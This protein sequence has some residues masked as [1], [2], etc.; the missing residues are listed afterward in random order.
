MRVL[1][2]GGSGNISSM[3]SKAAV[4]A[5]MELI[6]L[7]RGESTRLRNPEAYPAIKAD[8]GNVEQ[9]AKALRGLDFDA[10][11]DWIAYDKPDVE[12][13][14]GLFKGHTKQFIFISTASAYQRPLSHPVITEGTPL[15]NV[16]WE[17]SRKKIACET[18]LME[19]YREE[20]FPVTIVR[21]SHT[22]NTI[23]PIPVGRSNYTV[24]RRML[25][26]KSI[27]VPGD[28]SSLWTVTHAEDFAKGLVGLIGNMRAIGHAFHITSDEILTWNQII[29]TLADALGVK[30]NI[31]HMPSDF[32]SRFDEEIRG[33]LLGDKSWSVIFDNSKIKSFVPQF[34]ATIPFSEGIRRT[35]AWFDE[36]ERRKQIDEKSDKLMDDMAS[37]FQ[38]IYQE[39]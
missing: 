38:R 33:S 12:R 27:I 4:A 30:A 13:D 10:V 2:I 37:A 15:R 28:G 36:D 18:R 7:N 8:I 39:E 6:L 21:P 32:I 1:F 14:I 35:L 3:C 19:A 24:P 16:Y 26:G 34:K 25:D 11:V 5:G 23:V 29:E 31:L 20:G 22:Y 9:A 17:Y